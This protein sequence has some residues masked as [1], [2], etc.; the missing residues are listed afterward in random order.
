MSKSQNQQTSLCEL[1]LLFLKL[2]LT[3][4]GGPIAH[5]AMMKHEVVDLRNWLTEQEFLDYVGMTNLIPGPN[6]TELAIH[7][8]RKQRG[9]PGL[10]VAGLSFI[11]PAALIVWVLAKFYIFYGNL[12]QLS[13]A[14]YGIRPVVI[15]IVLHALWGLGNTVIKKKSD[16]IIVGLAIILNAIGG[17][18]ILILFGGGVAT[19]VLKNKFNIKFFPFLATISIPKILNAANSEILLSISLSKIFFFF[20]KVGSVLFGS[21][22]VL[23]AFLRADLV[24]R[25]HW[26]SNQQLMDA[27]AVGQLTPGPVFT[28]ATFVGYLLAGNSGALIATLGIFLPAFIFVGVSAYLIPHIKRSSWANTFLEG[29]NA[30][31]LSLMAVVSWRLG[32]NSLIDATTIILAIIS[33]FLLIRCRVNSAWLILLAGIGGQLI[34]T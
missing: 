15:A 25:W 18:E 8:G 31:S 14:L 16:A 26:I 19:L 5:I 3:S 11:F 32:L 13:G 23:L 4:F 7:I 34:A 2:G 1:A 33:F 28:T 24:D 22:Y 20:V 17:N 27:I 6:S 10:L 30:S 29:V 21:G 9:W 12:P